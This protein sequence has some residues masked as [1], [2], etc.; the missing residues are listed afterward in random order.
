MDRGIMV[1]ALWDLDGLNFIINSSELK[2]H[3][4]VSVKTPETNKGLILGSSYC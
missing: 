3:Q 1:G 4:T 2:S